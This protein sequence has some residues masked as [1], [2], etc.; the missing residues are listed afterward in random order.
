[1]PAEIS[2]NPTVDETIKQINSLPT[3]DIWWTVNGKDM[4]WN[5]KNL[6]KI[7]PTTT[8]YR[9]GQV[10]ALKLKAK[11]EISRLPVKTGNETMYFKDFLDSDLST[12][13]GV[14]ILHKGDIIF[15]HYPRMQVYE[16]PVYWS[17]TKVLVS[18][19]ISI[20]E[21]QKKIDIT[22]PIDLYLPELKQSD[23][24]GILIKNILDMATGINCSEEYIDKNSCYYK[25]SQ[26]VGDGY[27]DETSPS[28][29]Y[30]YIANLDVGRY[31]EQGKQFDYSGVNTFVLGWL[32]E[33]ITGMQFQDAF[34][35]MIWTKIGAERDAAFFAPRNGI[36][37][38]HGGFLSTQRDLAR[39]GLLFTPSYQVVSKDRIISEQHISYLL[40]QGR[41]ELIR[42]D[43]SRKIPKELKHNVY[44]WD[45]V[46][47]NNDIYKG[48]W[49]G[50]GLI[51]NPIND[52]VVVWNS[53]FKDKEES[54]IKLTPI[55]HQVLQSIQREK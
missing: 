14:L 23:F 47:Q 8:V 44:Q 55:I 32:V 11:H 16:K 36:P 52:Y 24:K 26:T 31:I 17:V 19:L 39:F 37:V 4:L 29:P 40:N 38:M 1:M 42:Y 9:K 45:M 54:E 18:S 13:M 20:L 22:K 50:Q 3:D 51:V 46:Y 21:D 33:K 5:F 6:N 35:E 30:E 27:W 12:A 28:N 34:S 7:F 43:N 53:Y 10:R 15:E 41:S 2:V 25:Y 48:G 49:A